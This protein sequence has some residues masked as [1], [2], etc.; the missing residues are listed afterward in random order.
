MHRMTRQRDYTRIASNDPE[1]LSEILSKK[2]SEVRVRPLEGG[3]DM[4][5]Q[6][7]AFYYDFFF[8]T[9][10]PSG[11]ALEKPEGSGMD[12]YGLF[13]CLKGSHEMKVGASRV[14]ATPGFASLG[15]M[16]RTSG[17]VY[18]AQSELLSFGFGRA[19]MARHMSDLIER[20]VEGSLELA[21]NID[22]A[23]GVGLTIRAMATAL[24]AGFSGEAPL[25]A[26][27]I[28]MKQMK[29]AVIALVLEGVPHRFSRELRRPIA[30]VSPRYVKRAIEFMYAN[31]SRPI[32]AAEIASESG[33]GVRALNAGFQ[34]FQNMP[35]MAYLREIRLNT[36]RQ[37]LLNPA[38]GASV[39]DIAL[40]W[41]FS[42]VS[43]F[44][45]KY[46]GR[47]GELPSQ[48]LRRSRHGW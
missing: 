39:A 14:A 30:G 17:Q 13:V 3:R 4:S 36:V 43:R 9:L 8:E 24:N 33:I 15:E 28:A 31:I 20:P 26:S 2:M 25:L 11:A 48:T 10:M 41:G 38:G 16:P 5:C 47:F 19:E 29:E 32:S 12:L 44:S 42:H 34:R 45:Q 23:K 7:T 18:S 1:E 6:I 21:A 22:L 46:Q 37:E 27:P 40:K 35:V